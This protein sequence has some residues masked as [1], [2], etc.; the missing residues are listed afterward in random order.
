MWPFLK[1]LW[2]D[3]DSWTSRVNIY[4]CTWR[5]FLP[6]LPLLLPEVK[7]IVGY[8]CFGLVCQIRYIQRIHLRQSLVSI[9]IDIPGITIN[10]S[11]KRTRRKSNAAQKQWCALDLS[12]GRQPWLK[13]T[14]E[15]NQSS[16][17]H[18]QADNL[19]HLSLACKRLSRI[20]LIEFRTRAVGTV[21]AQNPI[22]V[23]KVS[24][25]TISLPKRRET[26]KNQIL[27]WA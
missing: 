9:L 25:E 4:S 14:T 16:K 10:D 13:T 24:M 27:N 7:C 22:N 21:G 11:Q 18:S 12:E 19:T 26:E 15:Q 6:V 20:T 17:P 3:T 2:T 1:T 5:S 23:S 8:V